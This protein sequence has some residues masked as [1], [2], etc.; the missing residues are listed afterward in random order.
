MA[1]AIDPDDKVSLQ[2]V[3]YSEAETFND[4]GAT[5]TAIFR[6]G[7]THFRAHVPTDYRPDEIEVV[8]VK[9]QRFTATRWDSA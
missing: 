8:K 6:V 9:P 4:G 7:T 5:Q 1:H 2:L 3:H